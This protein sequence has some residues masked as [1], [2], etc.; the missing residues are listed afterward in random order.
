MPRREDIHTWRDILQSVPFSFARNSAPRAAIT[1]PEKGSSW[2]LGM[3][4][5]KFA[6]RLGSLGS[7]WRV[8]SE[9]S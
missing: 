5:H 4:V 8:L 3:T 6:L 2:L 1:P 7:A 9:M